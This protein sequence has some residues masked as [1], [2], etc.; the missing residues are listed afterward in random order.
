MRALQY[1][2][3]LV[4]LGVAGLWCLAMTVSHG[5]SGVGLAAFAGVLV[6]T[7]L[8]CSYALTMRGK[9]RTPIAR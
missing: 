7:A 5:L 2:L 9:H 3:V 6:C 8:F 1:W 4:L